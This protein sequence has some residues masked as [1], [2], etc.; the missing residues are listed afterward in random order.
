MVRRLL[1]R[2]NIGCGW[3][4]KKCQPV[5]G[6]GRWRQN[7][8]RKE[9]CEEGEFGFVEFNMPGGE[10]FICEWIKEVIGTLSGGITSECTWLGAGFEFVT[11]I[12]AKPWV[13]VAPKSS[14]FGVIE[15]VLKKTLEGRDIFESGGR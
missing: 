1:D 11:R 12:R 15:W 5:H 9:G 8:S 7:S 13:A 14:N 3:R 4:Q 6:H 10:N 2:S